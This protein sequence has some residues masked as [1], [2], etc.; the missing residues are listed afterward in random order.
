MEGETL[1]RKVNAEN[2]EKQAAKAGMPHCQEVH[3]GFEET[4]FYF[5]IEV[6]GQFYWSAITRTPPTSNTTSLSNRVD[7]QGGTTGGPRRG[8]PESVYFLLLTVY[9]RCNRIQSGPTLFPPHP[10][11][12]LLTSQCLINRKSYLFSFPYA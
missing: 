5:L 3:D 11:R 1:P 8:T 9:F 6:T 2:G 12:D 10:T 4:R 7:G